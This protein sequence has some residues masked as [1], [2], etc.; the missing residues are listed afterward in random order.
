MN[1]LITNTTVNT[2]ADKD[3]DAV[4]TNLTINWE[5]LTTEDI[6]AMAQQ[7]LIVKLQGA[8]RKNGIP[9]GDATI[10]AVD[11]K[12]GVRQARKPTDLASQI[13]A[14]SDEER[15]ALI[16]KLTAA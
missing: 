13:A 5:G 4:E 1:D 11:Y 14:L 10:N 12:V 6:R 2:R 7:A 9:S 15:A 3:S 8:W 16:A